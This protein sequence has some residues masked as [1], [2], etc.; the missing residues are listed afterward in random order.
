MSARTRRGCGPLRRRSC[1]ARPRTSPVSPAAF[2][3]VDGTV[4]AKGKDPYFAPWPD[5]VQV[6]A[7]APSLRSL[8]AAAAE[9]SR[10]ACGRGPLRHGDA[11]ARRRGDGDLGRAGRPAAGRDVLDRGDRAP[12]GSGIPAFRFVAEAYWDR[13]WDLQQLGFDYCYDKRLYDRLDAGRRRA[14]TRAPRRRPG[15]PGAPR[16]LPGEPRRAARRPDVRPAG[17]RQGRGGHHRDAA[18]HDA[19][20]R[21]P[22]RGPARSSSRCSSDA[23]PTKR[24]TTTW[25]TWYR[26]LWAAVSAAFATARGRAAR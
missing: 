8:A 18:G 16:A 7:F 6:N 10:R 1:A 3:E 4:F 24:P 12:C 17:A 5:V 9:P 25:P 13:E 15:V 20:A 23:G 14:G 19:V 22:G 11:D 26:D 21:R 2:V